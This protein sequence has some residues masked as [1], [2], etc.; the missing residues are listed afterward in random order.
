MA[1]GHAYKKLKKTDEAL[2]A[3]KEAER[4]NKILSDKEKKDK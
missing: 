3:F 2:A 1:L 4:I